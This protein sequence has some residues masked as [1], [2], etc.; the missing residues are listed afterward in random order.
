MCKNI[1]MQLQQLVLLNVNG[2][3]YFVLSKDYF[4]TYVVFTCAVS[5]NKLSAM[6]ISSYSM[7]QRAI[8]SQYSDHKFGFLSDFPCVHELGL[9]SNSFPC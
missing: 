6:F 2:K 9:C 7:Y 4:V 5:V 1:L 3:S 8:Y